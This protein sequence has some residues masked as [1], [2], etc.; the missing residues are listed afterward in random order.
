MLRRNNFGANDK[1]AWKR[2]YK[3]GEANALTGFNP[4]LF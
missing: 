3:P 1:L 2:V 4:D